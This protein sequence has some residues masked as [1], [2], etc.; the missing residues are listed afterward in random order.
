MRKP[1][2]PFLPSVLLLRLLA[3]T[4]P[5]MLA[6]ACALPANPVAGDDPADPAARVAR[7]AY[8]SVTAGMKSFR[9]VEPKGWEELNRQVGPKSP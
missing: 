9:P 3:V 5:A 8:V 1:P 7:P 4:A 6:S 2:S